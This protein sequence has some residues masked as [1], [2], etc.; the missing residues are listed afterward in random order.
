MEFEAAGDV[1]GL[2]VGVGDWGK[3]VGAGV[4]F[5]VGVAG[6]GEDDGKF[7]TLPP[8]GIVVPPVIIALSGYPSLSSVPKKL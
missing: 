2:P 5:W 8:P 4:E 3:A 6:F 1:V 7:G